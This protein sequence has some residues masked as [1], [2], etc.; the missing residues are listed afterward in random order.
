MLSA[1]CGSLDHNFHRHT[2][3][4]MAAFQTILSEL[5]DRASAASRG[6]SAVPPLVLVVE[7]HEDTR[8]L[9]RVLLEMR[10]CYVVEAGNGEE[11][12]EVATRERPDLILMDGALPRLD[13]FSATVRLRKLASLGKVPIVFVS[14]HAGPDYQ[15]AARA[16]GCN[17][18]LT[19]PI[20]TTRLDNVLG[21]YLSLKELGKFAKTELVLR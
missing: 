13:G 21:K 5:P 14:G 9:L 8:F 4:I 7:D 10:G 16:A 3:P 18:Y 17:D 2:I 19:K 1:K 15:R 12:I 11:A 20:D 6:R